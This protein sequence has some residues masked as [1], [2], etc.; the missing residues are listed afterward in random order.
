MRNKFTTLQFEDGRFK[1][2]N[3]PDTGAGGDGI[4]ISGSFATTISGNV[5]LPYAGNINWECSDPA[6]GATYVALCRRCCRSIA[7]HIYCVMTKRAK[8]WFPPTSAS[9]LKET[10]D[11]K[12]QKVHAWNYQQWNFVNKYC[13]LQSSKF[14]KVNQIVEKC[15]ETWTKLLALS[16]TKHQLVACEENHV[17]HDSAE[18]STVLYDS[19]KKEALFASCMVPYLVPVQYDTVLTPVYNATHTHANFYS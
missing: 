14:Q 15:N 7:L 17:I 19:A 11:S 9:Y 12:L 4:K 3:D 10:H 1:I 6:E 5:E 2:S 8:C 13:N 18:R 16:K